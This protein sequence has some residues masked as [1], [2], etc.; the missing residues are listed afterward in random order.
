MKAT[1]TDGQM[2]GRRIQNLRWQ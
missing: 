1:M 2:N